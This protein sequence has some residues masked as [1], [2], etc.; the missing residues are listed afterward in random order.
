MF[1]EL[2]KQFTNE[3]VQHTNEIDPDG[4]EDWHSLTVGWAIA[5]GLEPELARKFAHHIRYKTE[6]G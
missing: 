6:L 1:T 4:D 5:H 2:I 3:V